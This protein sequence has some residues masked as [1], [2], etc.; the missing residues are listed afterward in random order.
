MFK[1]PLKWMNMTDFPNHGW[2]FGVIIKAFY[3]TMDDTNAIFE[4]YSIGTDSSQNSSNSAES[5]SS[6]TETD[7]STDETSSIYDTTESE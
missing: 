2:R 1:I 6:S 3:I 5:D 7:S 4:T